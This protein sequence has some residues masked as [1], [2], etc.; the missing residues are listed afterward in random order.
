[1]KRNLNH[2]HW[3]LTTPLFLSSSLPILRFFF[4]SVFVRSVSRRFGNTLLQHKSADDLHVYFLSTFFPLFFCKKVHIT[5]YHF[6]ENEEKWGQKE[7]IEGREKEKN[8]KEKQEAEWN[9]SKYTFCFFFC[10]LMI[11]FLS[12]SGF[13]KLFSAFRTLKGGST[14]D[15]W[16]FPYF[17]ALRNKRKRTLKY[18]TTF[19]CLQYLH[20]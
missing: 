4:K 19:T 18:F 8:E 9:V 16:Q 13:C 17:L 20:Y 15:E 6:L 5:D 12:F 1:M 10:F 3:H 2:K 14:G 7:N 11:K